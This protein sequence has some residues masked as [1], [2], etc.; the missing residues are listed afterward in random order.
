M[1]NL[2]PSIDVSLYKLTPEQIGFKRSGYSGDVPPLSLEQLQKEFDTFEKIDRTNHHH[3][4]ALLELFPKYLLDTCNKIDWELFM[5]MSRYDKGRNLFVV[6]CFDN[7]PLELKL[8]SYKWRKLDGIKWKTRA[9]THPNGTPFIRIFSDGGTVYVIEGH[10]DMLS[11]ILL[12]LDFVMVPYSGFRLK[13][14]TA[15]QKEVASRDVVFIVEDEKAY[16]CMVHTAEALK[17]TARSI[18]LISLSENKE[19]VDLSSLTFLKNSIRE[20]ADELQD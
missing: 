14:P 10:R 15:M 19:K 9:G 5:S 1:G 2:E 13:D 12:G 16:K 6:G 20:V 8:I 11:A 3:E 7:Q 17:E 18:R 4:E